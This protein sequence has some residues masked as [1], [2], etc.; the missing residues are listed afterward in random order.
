MEMDEMADKPDCIFCGVIAG[1]VP[2]HIVDED[3]NCVTF[4]D[5][6]PAAPGH[7]LIVTRQR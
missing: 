4:M 2:A 7:T 5:V 3:E 6:F 1:H